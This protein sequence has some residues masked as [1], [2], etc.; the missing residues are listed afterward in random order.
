MQ[1]KQKMALALATAKPNTAAKARVER[2]LIQ[3][4][5]LLKN[6]KIAFE[7]TG[8]DS[9]AEYPKFHDRVLN[10]MQTLLKK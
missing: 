1:Y 3:Q 2:A 4:E 9:I 6:K 8:I 7:Q 10:S 5:S